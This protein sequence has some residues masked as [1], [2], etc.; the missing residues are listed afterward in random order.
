MIIFLNIET[1]TNL[2]DFSPLAIRVIDSIG[3]I[4]FFYKLF[5]FNHIIKIDTHKIKHQPK[6]R[7]LFEIMI[8][9]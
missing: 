3:L 7:H 9:T 5:L 6:N 2:I 8:T 4:I 1:M